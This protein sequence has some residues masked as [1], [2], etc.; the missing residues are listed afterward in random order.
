MFA[1]FLTQQFGLGPERTNVHFFA[2]V[3]GAAVLLLG[4]RLDLSRDADHAISS[5]DLNLH[6]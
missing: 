2:A 3:L 6:Q 5:P 1:T 4:Y